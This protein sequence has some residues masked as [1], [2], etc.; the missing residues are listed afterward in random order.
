M[1]FAAGRVLSVTDGHVP[2]A[3]ALSSFSS[4]A[5]MDMG[6]AELLCAF[7]VLEHKH[8]HLQQQQKRSDKRGTNQGGGKGA[9]KA[10]DSKDVPT[11]AAECTSYCH[12]HG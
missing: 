4:K 2:A 12:A 1:A 7:S 6:H 11:K 10:R 9:K 3:G 5:A 8:K